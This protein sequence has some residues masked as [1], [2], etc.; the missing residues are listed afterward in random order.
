MLLEAV[1]SDCRCRQKA[2][3]QRWSFAAFLQVRSRLYE[4]SGCL[5][6]FLVLGGAQLVI[7]TSCMAAG[8]LPLIIDAVQDPSASA[9]RATG[10]ITLSQV[11]D[12]QSCPIPA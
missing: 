10:V 8:L 1:P 7:D 11:R 6:W 3:D 4:L 2:D 12:I 9:L 5:F